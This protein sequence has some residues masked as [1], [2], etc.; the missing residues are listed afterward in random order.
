M[1]RSL[2]SLTAALL[3]MQQENS[4]TF[5]ITSSAT[6]GAGDIYPNGST[7]LQLIRKLRDLP[8][9]RTVWKSSIN[10]ALVLLKIYYPHPKQVRDV[11][12]E[13][14]NA[15]RLT[16]AGL[17]IAPPL[18]RCHGGAGEQAIAFEWIPDGDTLDQCLRSGGDPLSMF[19]LL[20][21]L[22][23]QQHNIGCY[24][25]DNHLGNYLYAGGQVYMLDSGSFIFTG[26]ALSEPQ[27][28]NN[29]AM[30]MAN[31]TLPLRRA[32]MLALAEYHEHCRPGIDSSRLE[33]E[34]TH[35]IPAAIQT[36]LW[37]YFKKTRR[38]C[39]EFEREDRAGKTWL[40][41][42]DLPFRLKELLLL[43]PD[44]FFNQKKILKDG[45]TCTVVEVMSEG[46]TYVLKRYN[47]KPLSY[48]LAHMAISPRALKSWTNGHVLNLFG[49]RTPRPLACL[50]VKSCGLME[51]AYLLMEQVEGE[52]LDKVDPQRITS[53][54]SLIPQAFARRW[55]EL[56][57]L[58]ATHGDMKASNFIVSP[59][60]H[61]A[62]IDL[63]GLKFDRTE[64]DHQRRREKDMKRFMRNWEQTPELAKIFRNALVEAES[65]R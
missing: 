25:A 45:N 8:D 32:A 7:E 21:A 16:E 26:A 37:K 40:A 54:E 56:E 2:D 14:G 5:D 52:T 38:S 64:N 42:R 6:P 59:E 46:K 60:G 55:Q 20:F 27:R 63:D 58:C 31:I 35:L 18:F 1:W 62:L 43:D 22:H 11:D 28:L 65:V 9:R 4:I 53:S 12:A 47:K 29:L 19:K 3:F 49:V 57:A 39:T 48:R 10:G 44:Q 17:K 50:L 36:R 15:I 61:L 24:Q 13:W 30:L 23:A 34:L 51:R 33:L 41:C